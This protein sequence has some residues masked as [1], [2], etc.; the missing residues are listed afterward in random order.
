MWQ[1]VMACAFSGRASFATMKSCA[2]GAT[3]MKEIILV[4]LAVDPKTGTVD[5]TAPFVVIPRRRALQ[6]LPGRGG[7]YEKEPAV[8]E[9]FP[10]GEREAQFEAEWSKQEGGWKFG[11]RI[12]DV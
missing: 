12:A 9:Q 2:A 3:A 5:R 11:K 7:L 4:R 10:P 6:R 1:T 8:I